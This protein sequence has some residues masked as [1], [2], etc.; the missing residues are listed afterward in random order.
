MTDILT[1]LA[2]LTLSDDS[3]L[4]PCLRCGNSELFTETNHGSGKGGGSV[5]RCSIVCDG[6]RNRDGVF[7][8]TGSTRA[9]AVAAWNAS[10]RMAALIALVQE[11]AGEIARLRVLAL[12]EIGRANGVIQSLEGEGMTPHCRFVVDSVQKRLLSQ[13]EHLRRLEA[14]SHHE[15][16]HG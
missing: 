6:C 7:G 10:A 15:A 14:V 11:A 16:V 8:G 5:K 9:H 3:R 13:E 1:R 12:G 2:G 4:L